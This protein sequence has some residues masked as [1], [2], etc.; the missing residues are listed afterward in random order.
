MRVVGDL[1]WG[2]QSVTVFDLQNKE[3][4]IEYYAYDLFFSPDGR[5]ALYR[6]Y[7]PRFS[8]PL[9]R[10]MLFDFAQAGSYG[11]TE[12][13]PEEVGTEIYPGEDQRGASGAEWPQFP[14]QDGQNAGFDEESR[15]A[16]FVGLDP[17]NL[18][19]VVVRLWQNVGRNS[20]ET[21]KV[22]LVSHLVRSTVGE[23]C[24]A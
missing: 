2:G 19:P 16:H 13:R 3:K 20:Y 15:I 24:T 8:E 4:I 18:V 22:P 9:S 17:Q 14:L 1:P 12:T 10:V 21:C 23:V 7:F 5:Y 11:N 6:R